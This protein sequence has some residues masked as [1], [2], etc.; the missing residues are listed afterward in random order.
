MIVGLIALT[1]LAVVCFRLGHDFDKIN[2]R[3]EKLERKNK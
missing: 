1:F 2:E 3:L